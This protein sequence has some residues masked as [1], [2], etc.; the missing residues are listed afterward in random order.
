[1]KPLT[2]HI[3]ELAMRQSARWQR[4]HLPLNIAVNLSSFNVAD[5]DLPVQL[6]R[7]T[8]NYGISPGQV[9]LEV[10]ETA[11]MCQPD[12]EHET[13]S[14]LAA[15]GFQLSI[16]DFGT[17][18]SSL[19]RLDQLP[20]RELK[21]DRSLIK[22]MKVEDQPA[23]VRSIIGLSHDL[24]LRVVAEGVETDDVLR[25]LE[26]L[27]CDVVQGYGIGM[28]VEPGEIPELVAALELNS[29]PRARRRVRRAVPV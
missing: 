14:A 16:D 23:L 19:A 20:F 5:E 4:E 10:T 25:R 12:E 9:T 2:M 7:L 3:V 17:G 11:A 24:G 15:R 28:P 29:T 26:A 27:G 18:Q 21:I 22:R 8:R 1:M 13:L 6:E